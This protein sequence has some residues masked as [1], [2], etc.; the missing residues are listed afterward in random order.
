MYTC[1]YMYLHMYLSVDLPMYLSVCVIIN[2]TLVLVG[3]YFNLLHTFPTPKEIFLK[4]SIN[5]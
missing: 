1:V 2:Q 5:N 3:N 4:V